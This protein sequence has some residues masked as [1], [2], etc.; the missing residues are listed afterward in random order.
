VLNGG[1]TT[2]KRTSRK[3]GTKRVDLEKGKGEDF[4]EDR[5]V[6]V[7]SMYTGGLELGRLKKKR[8]DRNDDCLKN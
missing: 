1:V 2:E 8:G 7:V 6:C 4:V 3:S 5:A